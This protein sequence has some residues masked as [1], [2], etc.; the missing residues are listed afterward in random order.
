MAL[1][2]ATKE[3][4]YLNNVLRYIN[5]KLSLNNNTKPPSILVD[6]QGA[7]KLAQNPEFHKRTKHIDISYHFIRECINNNKITIGFIPSRE[8]LA[9]GFTK[10]LDNTK[11]Q[12]LI[13]NLNINKIT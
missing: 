5:L 2:E 4:I 13:N 11:Q 3:S 12:N 1:K 7:L 10:A 9:D 6:N 8:Q